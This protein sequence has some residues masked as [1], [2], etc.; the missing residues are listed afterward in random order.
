MDVE[1]VAWGIVKDPE[2]TLQEDN[3][4]EKAARSMIR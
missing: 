4:D 3:V 1:E 2:G